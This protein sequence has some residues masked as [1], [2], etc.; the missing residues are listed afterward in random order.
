MG[1]GCM[2][3]GE[4]GEGIGVGEMRGREGW[5]E[6]GSE[7]SKAFA[8]AIQTSSNSYPTVIKQLPK[9]LPYGGDG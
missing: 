1:K 2:G 4:R 8:K 3:R 5:G 9:R 7:V 6:G